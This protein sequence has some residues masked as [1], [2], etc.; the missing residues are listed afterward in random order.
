M[1]FVKSIWKG[2]NV[3]RNLAKTD[4]QRSANGHKERV[5]VKDKT[6]I[7]S[8]LHLHA[9]MGNRTG[10][11]NIFHVLDAKTFSKTGSVLYGML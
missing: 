5:G 2:E 1:K 11:T 3:I 9:M 10:L 8:M 6:V 7:T 4:I